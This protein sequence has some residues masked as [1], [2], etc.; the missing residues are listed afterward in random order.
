MQTNFNELQLKDP[1]ISEADAMLRRCVHCGFC[2]ATCPTYVLTGD[3]RDSPRGRIYLINRDNLGKLNLTFPKGE[4]AAPFTDPRPFDEHLNGSGFPS[5]V[6]VLGE[7]PHCQ[8]V[9]KCSVSSG[10][11]LNRTRLSSLRFLTLFGTRR[12]KARRQSN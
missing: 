8:T 2:N 9:C 12:T 11:S 3:E 5:G 1:V 7:W 4:T 10:L 6:G